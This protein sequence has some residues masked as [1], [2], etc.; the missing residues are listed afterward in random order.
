MP[1][2]YADA[3]MP[4]QRDWEAEEAFRT[5]RR[6]KEIKRDPAMMQRV[7]VFAEQEKSV[8]REV[9]GGTDQA[10]KAAAQGYRKLP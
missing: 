7:A 4:A 8:I 3:P 9:L 10:A 1:R 6:A 2:K 5:L